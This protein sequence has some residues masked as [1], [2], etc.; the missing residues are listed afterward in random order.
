MESKWVESGL[1]ASELFAFLG[2]VEG[3]FFG[4]IGIFISRIELS[5]NFLG[6]LRLGRRQSVMVLHGTD[7]PLLFDPDFPL[8]NYLEAHLS[9]IAIDN[10]C[11]YSADRFLEE[12]K[13]DSAADAEVPVDGEIANPDQVAVTEK[14][15]ECISKQAAKN[16]VREYAEA[17]TPAQRLLAAVRL[18]RNF[19][20]VAAAKAAMTNSWRGENLLRLLQEVISRLPDEW[21][22]ADDQF[23]LEK[24]SEDF[25]DR[26]Y[27]EILEDF[28]PRYAFITP[29]DQITFEKRLVYQW[30]DNFYEYDAENRLALPTELLWPVLDVETKANLI[31]FFIQII[32][33]DRRPQYP[34]YQLARKIVQAEHANPD[35]R[36]AIESNFDSIIRQGAKVW[37]G[38]GWPNVADR[39]KVVNFL[40]DANRAISPYVDNYTQR[41]ENIV[42][43][44]QAT[45]AGM[46]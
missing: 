19:K 18:V 11:H 26:T 20:T 24:L 33:S 43:K 41:I 30:T 25:Q 22:N 15:K 13:V 16:L 12:R 36:P 2:K 7:I 32:L 31:R 46:E 34:Q 44:E 40:A 4:T 3:K 39:P 21:T 38:S 8:E 37:I 45:V 27:V 1:A 14:F 23:F 9:H 35:L 10:A 17:F 29:A 5:K 42:A 28:V 6:A